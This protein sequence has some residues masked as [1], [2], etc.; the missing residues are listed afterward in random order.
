MARTAAEKNNL[1]Q[2][3][4]TEFDQKNVDTVARKLEAE[5]IDIRRAGEVSLTKIIRHLLAKAAK[6]K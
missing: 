3:W 1:K 6:D 5:G 2:I 4:L